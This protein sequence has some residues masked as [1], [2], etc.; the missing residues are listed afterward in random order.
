MLFQQSAA[1]SLCCDATSTCSSG[2]AESC[3]CSTG[4]V[5]DSNGQCVEPEPHGQLF[6]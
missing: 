6:N 4:Q 1:D 5:A 3:F 2:G